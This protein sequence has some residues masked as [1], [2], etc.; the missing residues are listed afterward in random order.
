MAPTAFLGLSHLGVVSSIGWASLGD[1]VVAV[2]LDP[3]P[4]SRLRL[5]ELSVLEPFLDALFAAT[6]GRM[7]FATD[8]SLVRDSPLV[9]VDLAGPTDSGVSSDVSLVTVAV[10]AGAAD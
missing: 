7:T 10:A 2:D 9:V 5:G 1:A 3:E 8:V 6:R 4:V